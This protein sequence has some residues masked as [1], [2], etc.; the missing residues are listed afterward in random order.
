MWNRLCIGLQ[1]DDW[2]SKENFRHYEN[3]RKHAKEIRLR[4][5]ET[6]AQLTA[7]Q[8]IELAIKNDLPIEM[9]N[10]EDADSKSQI[11]LRSGGHPCIPLPVDLQENLG[12]APELK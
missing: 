6:V 4:L 9:I 7:N 2:A 12:P 11:Q 8:I 10:S 5:D 3:R 1:W